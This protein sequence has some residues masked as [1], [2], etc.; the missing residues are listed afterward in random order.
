MVRKFGFLKELRRTIV[1]LVKL[2]NG[3]FD[4]NNLNEDNTLLISGGVNLTL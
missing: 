2:K 3:E 4:F 1:F